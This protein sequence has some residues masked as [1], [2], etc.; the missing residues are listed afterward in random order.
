MLA[1]FRGRTVRS[2]GSSDAVREELEQLQD[3]QLVIQ[4]RTEKTPCW[5]P[6]NEIKERKPTGIRLGDLDEAYR[7][8]LGARVFTGEVWEEPVGI[9]AGPYRVFGRN[10]RRTS[11]STPST[12][13]SRHTAIRSRYGASSC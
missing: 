13:Q 3:A 5:L 12:A 1:W 6:E 7:A 10:L 8:S 4:Y 2:W 11:E 9:G